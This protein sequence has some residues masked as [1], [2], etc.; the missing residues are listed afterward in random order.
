MLSRGLLPLPGFGVVNHQYVDVF[1][2]FAQVFV[3]DR[4]RTLITRTN[5]NAAVV[6]PLSSARMAASLWP[7]NN[8]ALASHETV[9]IFHLQQ[10]P[11]RAIA[12]H[13]AQPILRPNFVLH[14]VQMILDG[15]F[16]QTKMIGNLLVRQ[17]LGDEPNQLLFPPGESQSLLHARSVRRTN[18]TQFR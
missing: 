18:P 14:P 7:S 9:S 5:R 2:G 15:L 13:D 6:W 1:Q 4:L 11:M 12:L 16:R 8:L 17:P 10:K 3:G